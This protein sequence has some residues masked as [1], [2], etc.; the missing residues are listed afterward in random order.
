MQE[1]IS[2]GS[3][4]F[5]SL[6]RI[7]KVSNTD[8]QINFIVNYKDKEMYFLRDNEDKSNGQSDGDMVVN[9]INRFS[10]CIYYTPIYKGD[11]IKYMLDTFPDKGP[12]KVYYRPA[13]KKDR[14]VFSVIKAIN[15]ILKATNKAQR[16]SWVN[17]KDSAAQWLKDNIK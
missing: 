17:N 12:K 13:E 7:G 3:I 15:L 1:S 14:R 4:T 5:H 10:D 8:N 2:N 6:E 16:D 11:K 9:Y